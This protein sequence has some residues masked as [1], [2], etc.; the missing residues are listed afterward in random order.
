MDIF[1]SIEDKLLY[2]ETLVSLAT[3]NEK[4]T[5]T[6]KSFVFNIV[7]NYNLPEETVEPIWKKIQTKSSLEQLLEPVKIQVMDFKLMLLQELI[8]IF[9]ITNRYNAEKPR[10]V[11]MCQILD[12]NV[13]L[14]D[15]K[16]HVQKLMPNISS[17]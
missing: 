2:V 9:L 17:N 1:K 15:L 14:S 4:I 6:Q 16:S 11:K 5:A 7:K 3:Y 13:K 8:M 12:I 10:L